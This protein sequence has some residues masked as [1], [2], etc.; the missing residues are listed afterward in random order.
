MFKFLSNKEFWINFVSA[1]ATLASLATLITFLFDWRSECLGTGGLLL[2]GIGI[3]GICIAYGWWMTRRKSKIEIEFSHTF[4]LTIEFGNLFCSPNKSIF[5]IPVNQYFDTQLSNTLVKRDSVMGNFISQFWQDRLNELNGKIEEGLKDEQ[6]EE[7]P[8]RKDGKKIKYPLGTCA[9][10]FDGGNIYVL[11]VTTEKDSNDRSI[12]SK[13]DYPTVIGSL[14]KFLDSLGK[15]KKIHM[16][17]FGTG[18]GRLGRS[19]QRILSFLIDTLDF[20]YADLSFP[21]GVNI[22]IKDSYKGSI[23]LNA[24]ASHFKV[25]LK[26]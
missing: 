2:L 23:N 7:N 8:N 18:R 17:L 16:P 6:G 15:D 21:L 11:V 24:I 12:L 10:I 5:V 14:F 9:K 3:L 4:K 19:R 22:I 25:A 20:K 13:K 1:L 26:D